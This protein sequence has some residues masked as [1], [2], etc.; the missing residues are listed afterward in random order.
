MSSKWSRCRWVTSTASRPSTTTSA[1]SGSS[2]SGL[3]RSFS[4]S[5][6]GG[7]APAG[8]SIGSTSSCRPS[9][10]SRSVAL[11]IRRR[12]IAPARYL[13]ADL[14]RRAQRLAHSAAMTPP[15]ICV[16]EDEQVIAAA[17]AARLRAEGFGVEVAHDGTAGVA[18][19]DRLRPDLV[20]LDLMLPGLDGLEVCRR[21]SATA[22]PGAHADRA[23]R[24]DR[25]AGRARRG[26][27][28]LHD[29]AVLPARAR[30][31]H[32]RAAAPGGAPPAPRAR[33]SRSGRSRSTPS[34]AGSRSAA[35]RSTSRR[36]SSTCSRCSPRGPA[37]CSRATSCWRRCGAGATGP[38][39]R[40][41][42]SHVRGLRRKLGAAGCGPCTASGTRSSRRAA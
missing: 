5:S 2:T 4:V 31:A 1:G 3:R 35:P 15:L 36:R 21:S 11:R 17:V 27:R 25:R 23:R 33:R 40:T 24:R 13:H 19:C 18:L 28:R 41:V 32:P 7:R 9:S 14:A 20:V 8:S 42:D 38:G 26:R 22:R 37:W 29:Q 12:C 10:S 6:T 34:A 16:I 39:H 30:R